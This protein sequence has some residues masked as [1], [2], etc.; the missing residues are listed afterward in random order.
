MS[1]AP[2]LPP[3]T[4]PEIRNLPTIPLIGCAGGDAHS[5]FGN[6]F[7]GLPD[8]ESILHM[9]ARIR[10]FQ[11]QVE[12]M[13]EG[14]VPAIP[15][16]VVWAIRVEQYLE[17]IA[18]L[19][20]AITASITAITDYVNASLGFINDKINELNDLKAALESVPE[21]LRSKVQQK[22]IERYNKYLG[23]LATQATRLQS[24]LECI[25]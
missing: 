3:V 14:Y 12:M 16:Q 9:K 13:I 1:L 4:L 22:M 11:E 10:Y 2:K 20:A 15:R 24:T 7:G 23:R 5:Y 17:A 21:G 19:T 25:G 6:Q 8:L 18:N